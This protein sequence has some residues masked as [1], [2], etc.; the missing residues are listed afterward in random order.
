MD[1]EISRRLED[2]VAALAVATAGD[3]SVRLQAH[4][5]GPSVLLELE[6]GVNALFQELHLAV[7]ER[8]QQREQLHQQA[9][10]IIEQQR[11]LLSVL[12]TPAIAVWP[13][14]L[15][16]PI[17][18]ALGQERAV[19]M[20]ATLL[21]RVVSQRATHVILDL[22]GARHADR[23]SVQVLM[24]MAQAIRLLGCR[25]IMTGIPAEL[26]AAFVKL[27]LSMDDVPALPSLSEALSLVFRERGLVL[28]HQG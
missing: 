27:N 9:L 15:V 22:T 12:S 6:Y 2:V 28:K 13:Q 5:D 18:G 16:L 25:C 20:T 3:L 4:E 24:Q 1:S 8:E 10:Q 21:G 11:S 23:Q 17:L 26:A 7:R 14:V 19:E